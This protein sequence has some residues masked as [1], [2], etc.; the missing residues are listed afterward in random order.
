MVNFSGP[1]FGFSLL[2]EFKHAD[3]HKGDEGYQEEHEKNPGQPLQGLDY[4]SVN[5]KRPSFGGELQDLPLVLGIYRL[6]VLLQAVDPHP[7]GDGNYIKG[8]IKV[9]EPRCVDWILD[10]PLEY[11]IRRGAKN[12]RRDEGD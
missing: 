4:R 12:P 5:F 11:R 7:R 2:E 10:D 6:D 3:K 8:E 9:F 1:F